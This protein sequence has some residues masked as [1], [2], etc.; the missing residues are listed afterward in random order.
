MNIELVREKIKSY[1]GK[2]INFRFNGSRNQI[3]EFSAMV[4]DTYPSVFT[5]KVVDSSVVKSFSYADVLIRK[6]V[7]LVAS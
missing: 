4:I 2:T 5:V 1:K 3:E 7:V 6:L